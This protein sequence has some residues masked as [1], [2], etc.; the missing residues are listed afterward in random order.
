MPVRGE[1]TSTEI[2]RVSNVRHSFDVNKGYSCSI[3]IHNWYEVVLG[4]LDKSKFDS[5]GVENG[6]SDAESENDPPDGGVE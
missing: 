3:G 5:M 6:S 1:Y 4:M 2:H